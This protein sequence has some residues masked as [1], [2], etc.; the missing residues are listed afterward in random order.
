MD[1][2]LPEISGHIDRAY[3]ATGMDGPAVAD[4]SVQDVTDWV[5]LTLTYTYSVSG[6][7]LELPLEIVEY[8]EDGLEFRRQRVGLTAE[9]EYFNGASSYTVGLPPGEWAPGL[10]YVYVYAGGRKVA[11]VE[12]EVTP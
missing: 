5:Y 10:Y 8:Y 6:G 4:F 12:F 1:P 2:T 7:L 3:I 9:P 11:E